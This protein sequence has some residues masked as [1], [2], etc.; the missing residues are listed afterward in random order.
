[1]PANGES[2][3]LEPRTKASRGAT[4][5][6]RAPVGRTTAEAER[7]RVGPLALGSEVRV[8]ERTPSLPI[9][10]GREPRIR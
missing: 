8:R 7:C 4:P 2:L 5:R 10:F 1:M 9:A 3:D 6:S